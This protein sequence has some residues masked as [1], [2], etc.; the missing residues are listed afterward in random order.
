MKEHAR[1]YLGGLL[2]DLERKNIES[3]AYRYD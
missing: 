1:Q 2:S 3:I